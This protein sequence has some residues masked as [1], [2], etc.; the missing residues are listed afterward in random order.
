MFQQNEENHSE[1][2]LNSVGCGTCDHCGEIHPLAALLPVYINECMCKACKEA[3]Q[4]E[5]EAACKLYGFEFVGDASEFD[6]C[7]VCSG[8]GEGQYDGS[9]CYACH[10]TGVEK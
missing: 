2:A 7:G 10:G 6:L 5:D 4:Q 9:R 8:S 1:E 3:C